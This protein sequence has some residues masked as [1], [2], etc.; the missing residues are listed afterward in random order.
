MLAARGL[1]KDVDFLSTVSGG[2]YTGSFLT[3]RLG[4]DEA[5]ADVGV[6]MGPTA[7]IRHLRHHAK[8]L[9]AIDLK[10]RWSMVTAT[11]AGMILNW[12]APV[13]LVAL[14]ALGAIA[15]AHREMIPWRTAL[16]G[17]SRDCVSVTI[18]RCW[19]TPCACG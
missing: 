6:P 16:A 19:S 4:N 12:S 1:L 11:L 13:F 3:A 5:Y 2:G 10:D 15:L 9:T 8:Y 17:A 7:A 14:A 18:L